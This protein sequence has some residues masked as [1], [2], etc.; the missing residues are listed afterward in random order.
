[1]LQF[2][3]DQ[4]FNSY[5]FDW[6]LLSFNYC[7]LIRVESLDLQSI[8]FMV[9]SHIEITHPNMGFLLLV[10][11]LHVTVQKLVLLWRCEWN[12]VQIIFKVTNGSRLI[13]N[14]WINLW[15]VQ[16]QW[17]ELLTFAFDFL[18]L[19]IKTWQERLHSLLTLILNFGSLALHPFDSFLYLFDVCFHQADM[20]LGA[21]SDPRHRMLKIALTVVDESRH[22]D[23]C[24]LFFLNHPLHSFGLRFV[25]LFHRLV[26]ALKMFDKIAINDL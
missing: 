18:K 16:S 5:L 7:I 15:S 22:I 24:S 17:R 3:L 11:T 26:L 12:F 23:L 1:M 9:I 10:A 19:F 6:I 21:V 14:L 13:E 8:D 2:E 20:L 4:L 25:F